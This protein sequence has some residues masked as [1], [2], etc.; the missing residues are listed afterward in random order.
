MKPVLA[1][2]GHPFAAYRARAG[3]AATIASDLYV[4]R[5]RAL[6]AAGVLAAPLVFAGYVGLTMLLILP[7]LGLRTIFPRTAPST[8]PWYDG[9]GRDRR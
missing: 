7:L 4:P 5:N 2:I 1:G 9:I 6:V 3:D 8:G